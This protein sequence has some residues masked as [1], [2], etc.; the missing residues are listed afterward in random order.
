MPDD[1][2]SLING[3]Q[4]K[5]QTVKPKRKILKIYIETSIFQPTGLTHLQTFL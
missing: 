4:S 1:G 5:E 2:I 3:S